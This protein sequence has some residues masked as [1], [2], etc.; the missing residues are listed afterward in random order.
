MHDRN[1]L[2]LLE[3]V[4]L[5]DLVALLE[6]VELLESVELEELEQFSSF[7][8]T[9]I[10]IETNIRTDSPGVVIEWL[11][12]SFFKS[13]ILCMADFRELGVCG[14]WVCVCKCFSRLSSSVIG[15][16]GS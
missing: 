14:G 4:E 13:A 16:H 2:E 8:Y 7:T 1:P 6:M 9:Y 10:F 15:R 5:L 12:F 11:F 3:L